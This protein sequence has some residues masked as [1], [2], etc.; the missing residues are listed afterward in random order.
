MHFR[1]EKKK[2]KNNSV[3][4]AA[5]LQ[6]QDLQG[7]PAPSTNNARSAE[8]FIWTDL[9]APQIA[10]FVGKPNNHPASAKRADMQ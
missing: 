2:T 8:F 5:S 9:L 3:E 1:L 10:H 6:S 7:K 4:K